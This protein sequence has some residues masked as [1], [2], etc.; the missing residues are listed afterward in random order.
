MLRRKRSKRDDL[1]APFTGIADSERNP[2]IRQWQLESAATHEQCEA[3]RQQVLKHQDLANQLKSL[4]LRL[5]NPRNWTG[6]IPPQ[7]MPE[8]ACPACRSDRDN[9]ACRN[10]QHLAPMNRSPIRAQLLAILEQ[11]A[12]R[13]TSR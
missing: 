4:P 11:V 10:P 13:E 9:R 8:A 7:R 3:R 12:Q 1:P 6:Y 5:S 2:V